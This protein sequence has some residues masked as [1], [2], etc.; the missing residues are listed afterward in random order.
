MPESR[1]R[2]KVAY[3]PPPGKAAPRKPNPPWF[4]PV[5]LSLMVIG[6]A[7][8]VVTYLTAQSG[9]TYPIP[10]IGQWNLAAGF[11]LILIGFGMT[12]RW[13]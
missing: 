4:V 2:K 11:G 9:H 5:M 8:I 3:T 7:W 12:T 1:S 6:L 10:G 13:R